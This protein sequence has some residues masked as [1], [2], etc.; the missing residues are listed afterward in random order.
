MEIEVEAKRLKTYLHLSSV[1]YMSFWSVKFYTVIR[2]GWRSLLTIY[3][4]KYEEDIHQAGYPH[5]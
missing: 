1:L 5:T 2:R 4:T 3:I